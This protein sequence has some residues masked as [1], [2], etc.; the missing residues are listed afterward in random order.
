MKSVLITIAFALAMLPAFTQNI[1]VQEIT[2]S[3]D[4]DSIFEKIAVL[5]EMDRV[6]NHLDMTSATYLVNYM[7]QYDVDTVYLHHYN[8]S[9]LPNVVAI[10]YGDINPNQYLIVGAHYD[11]VVEKAGADDNGSGTAAVLDMVRASHRYSF[12][13]SII[14]VLFSAEET[15][16]KGSRAFA[17]S[18]CPIENIEAMFNMDMIAYN[19][20]G[21]DT[22]V[23][24][25]VNWL[26][27]NLLN[28]YMLNTTTYVPDLVIDVDSVSWVVNASDHR[29]FWHHN[30]P[31]LFLIETS[32]YYSNDWN[33]YYHTP[34]DTIGTSANSPM[35]AEKITRSVAASLFEIAMPFAHV[36]SNDVQKK[37]GSITLKPNPASNTMI[38]ETT[39]EISKNSL[40]NIYASNGRLVESIPLDSMPA[41]ININQ[42]DKGNYLLTL[43]TKKKVLSA[44]F[45]KK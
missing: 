22:S 12:E 35:L 15:G 6:A 42:Y 19:P 14:F 32:D 16:L 24:V 29:S 40:L 13:K 30:V 21:A 18:I 3:I 26:S 20:P 1:Y 36:G 41:T 44:F 23:S 11:A 45:I 7:A 37:T 43:R 33:P 39:A 5:Q 28:N 27:V 2:N 38:I 10:K 34:A 25:C 17:D 4:G 31:S 9:E 8:V